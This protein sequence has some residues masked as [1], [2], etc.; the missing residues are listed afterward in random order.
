MRQS[1][2]F[3]EN[4]FDALGTDIA[5][6]GGFKVVAGKLWPTESPAM[7]TQKLRNA[8]NPE[9]PHKLD[10]DEVIAIKRLARD[11]GSTAMVE[12]EAMLLGFQVTWVDPRDE[13][14][15][16]R[17]QVLTAAAELK[18]LFTR[19]EKAEERTAATI[20]AGR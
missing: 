2:L 3:H 10:P 16:L 6:A 8:V 12:Y 11:A 13:A 18:Q 4:V 7:A 20:K 9:Q 17:R 5:A 19:I 14:A 1:A 15:E